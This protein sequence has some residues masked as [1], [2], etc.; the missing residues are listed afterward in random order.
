MAAGVVCTSTARV[1]SWRSF[2]ITTESSTAGSAASAGAAAPSNSRALVPAPGRRLLF[3][4]HP[5][6]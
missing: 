5:S 4:M 2:W 6:V 3:D 1:R